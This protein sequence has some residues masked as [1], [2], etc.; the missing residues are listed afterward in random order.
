[1]PVVLTGFDEL[2]AT[3]GQ[4]ESR[5]ERKQILAAAMRKALNPL[6]DELG[7]LAPDDPDTPGNRIRKYEKIAVTDQSA[8]SV[9]GRVGVTSKG[10]VGYLHEFGTEHMSAHPFAGP[11]F[12]RT[13]DR[14]VDLLKQY[15]WLGI[16]GDLLEEALN[17]E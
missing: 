8:T 17:F 5:V 13:F 12:D 16:N 2:L 11:A 15:L 14:I 4:I 7:T 6:F 10:F 3:L 1:M 9:L